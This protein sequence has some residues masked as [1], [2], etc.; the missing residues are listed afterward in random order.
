MRR[1]LLRRSQQFIIWLGVLPILLAFVAY[2][3]SSQHVASVEATLSTDD[4]I[5]K[6]DELLSLVQDA[7]TGQRGY[8]LTGES[9]YL[10]PFLN[11]QAQLSGRLTEI[12]LLAARYGVRRE[13]TNQL[14]DLVNHK[15]AE[16]ERTVALRRQG[17]AAAALQEVRT[18]IG[19]QYMS[20]IRVLIGRL[21]AEQV[22][23]FRQRLAQQRIRQDQ[24][25]VVLGVG[26]LLGFLFLVMAYRL[27]SLYARER[28][29]V[30]EE[31][32]TLNSTLES[33]V[34][35]RTV[36]LEARTK[37]L[38]Y[39]TSEL[40]RS[41]AD[42]TTFAY[43]AS[44]DLQEPLRMVSSYVGLL[45]RRYGGKLDETA[46]RYI[47]F[48]VDGSKRMQDLIQDLLAY[49]RAGTEMVQKKQ[50]SLEQIVETA[51][52]NLALRIQES[53]AVVRF[54]GLPMVQADEIKLGQV[55]QNLLSNAIKF[56]KPGV[57][58]EVAISAES[59]GNEWKVAISDNGI[60]FEQKYS[61]RIFQIFQR[62]HGLGKYPGT[63][64]GLAI[65]RRIIEHHGGRLWAESQPDA[66]SI[67]Y[68]TLP[69]G[70]RKDS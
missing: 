69:A 31:I 65:S 27:S 60:G 2:R 55:I 1:L 6:L 48:A 37:E 9:W 19:Q 61:E 20:E 14:R 25:D 42:L 68:F 10:D 8:L 56:H 70:T 57:S 32:R 46:D 66:G 22:S 26:V 24:L 36:E 44:H 59:D 45:A 30:E 11:A 39:R 47:Q 23:A 12:E 33:R 13:D 29:Q 58:P 50:V 49:S 18:N 7:E 53:S 51:M 67:F 28:D 17:Q 54:N 63:G 35:E 40:Q 52:S 5:R 15:M 41:N 4:F 21:K 64:I 38:E 3:T 62:L 16:L 43:A 34:K